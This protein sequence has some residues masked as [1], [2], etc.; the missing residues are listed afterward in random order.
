MVMQK[1]SL[2]REGLVQTYPTLLFLLFF[3]SGA[4]QE[5][6]GHEALSPAQ[7]GHRAVTLLTALG[8]LSLL[9]H[10]Q[11]S[12]VS[13]ILKMCLFPLLLLCI[14]GAKVY[15]GEDKPPLAQT[16]QFSIWILAD[17]MFL[18]Q[19]RVSGCTCLCLCF[20]PFLC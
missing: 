8:H 3:Q 17:V 4:Q 5:H 9:S 19:L 14:P 10:L 1:C 11:C 13:S 7:L 18:Q 15:S 16:R 12:L 6:T 2:A 20:S